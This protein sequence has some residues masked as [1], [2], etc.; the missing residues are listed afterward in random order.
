MYIKL[1]YLYL[2]PFDFE[3]KGEKILPF[4]VKKYDQG[5]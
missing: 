4:S 3:V 2:S 1:D 5:Q